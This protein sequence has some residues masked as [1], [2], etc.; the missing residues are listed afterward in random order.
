MSMK[1]V[2]CAYYIYAYMYTC[3][4]YTYIHIYV[5]LSLRVYI[6]DTYYSNFVVAHTQIKK[7]TNNLDVH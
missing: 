6:K 1:H 2:F 7:T 5:F 3:Y 4:M